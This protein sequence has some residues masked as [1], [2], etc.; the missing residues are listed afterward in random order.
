MN[1][2]TKK[3]IKALYGE[4][5]FESIINEIIK[6]EEQAKREARMELAENIL[7]ILK[8]RPNVE[9]VNEIILKTKVNNPYLFNFV[10]E[11]AN[12]AN[13]SNEPNSNAE[14]EEDNISNSLSDIEWRKEIRIILNNANKLLTPHRVASNLMI[15]LQLSSDEVIVRKV[16][17]K[18][19]VVLSQLYKVGEIN[20]WEH[21]EMG[22]NYP[23]LFYGTLDKFEDG[24]PKNMYMPLFL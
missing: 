6:A 16:R 5:L 3:R 20:R 22:N 1:N 17:E 14:E 19:S 21:I 10:K 4:I 7:N 11:S 23:I 18:A 12:E 24:E 15:S 13:D 2:E 8:E 9:N